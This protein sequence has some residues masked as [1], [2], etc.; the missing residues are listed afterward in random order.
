MSVIDRTKQTGFTIVELL[1]VIVVIGILAAITIVA[2]NG[3]Q[4]RAQNS[5]TT[6]AVNAYIK[7]LSIYASDNGAYPA[8]FAATNVACLGEDYIGDKCWDSSGTYIEDSALTTALKTVMGSTLPMPSLSSKPNSGI[9]YLPK[10]RHYQ[11]DG[12][13]TTW[14]IYAMDGATTRCSVGPIASYIGGLSFSSTA[15]ASGQ[16]TTG[17]SPGCWMPL[18]SV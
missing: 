6:S 3:I 11:L 1:I 13:D 17:T 15:P 14:I 12:V 2:Y 18:P 9:L 7:G 4:Q 10:N 16:T 8:S 5:K